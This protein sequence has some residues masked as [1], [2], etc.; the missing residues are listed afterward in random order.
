MSFRLRTIFGLAAAFLAGAVSVIAAEAM[1]LKPYS[2]QGLSLWKPEAGDVWNCR[3][4]GPY[5][6]FSGIWVDGF[7]DARFF[8]NA[9]QP[10]TEPVPH[11]ESSLRIDEA[12][13]NMLF[14]ASPPTRPMKHQ[15]VAISFWGNELRSKDG[16]PQERH[17]FVVRRIESARILKRIY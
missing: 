12:A 1:F 7:E 5:A 16:P 11:T 9:S 8:P 3:D 17:L 4:V 6:R 15:L 13:R 10:P 14:D 2:C